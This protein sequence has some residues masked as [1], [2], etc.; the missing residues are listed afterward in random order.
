MKTF[1]LSM[2]GALVAM[3]IFLILM[4]I[5]FVGI[6]FSAA[7]SAPD[8]PD[9]IILSLD[10]NA[11]YTDQAPVSGFAAFSET[12]G[13]VDLLTKL[14]AAETDDSVKGLYLRGATVGIGSSRAE[15][16]REALLSFR[17]SGKFVIAHT[18][19]AFGVGGPSALRSITPADEVWIQP[20][21]EVFA[22]GVT[23][24][25]EFL[26]GLFDKIDVTPEIYPFYEYKNAPN[27]YNETSYTEPHREA[28]TQLA[29]SLW[30]QSLDDIAA[31]RDLSVADVKAL[32]E[33]GPMTSE[34]AIANKLMDKEGYPEEAEEAAKEKA[35]KGAE[36]MD[37]ASYTP[38][39]L[40]LKA[41]AIAI[42]GGEGAVVTGSANGGS[43][44]ESAPAFASDT[45]ARAI[46]D[47][48]KNDKVKAIV[49]RVDSPGGSP[50]ASDQIWNAIERVQADGKPVVVSMGSLAA[51]G[52]Y[53]VSA[54]ADYIVANR[55]TITGSIG[56]FGG[57]F[58]LA[59]GFNKLGITFDTIS[60]GG[61]FADAYG[62]DRFTPEQEAEVKASLKR[63]YDR[64]VGIVAEGRGMTFD[65]VN[66]VARGHVW[67]GEDALER[68]LVDE[69][70]S[71]T[72]AIAKAKELAGIDADTTPRLIYYP[73][74]KSGFEALESL[75][76]ASA[77]TAESM[78]AIS[79]LTDDKRV[80]VLLEELATAR[81]LSS[82]EAQAMGPRIRER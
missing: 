59:G 34:Q 42:V 26:K 47:A 43:P 13:F 29:E 70:G 65:E 77:E 40:P 8:A 74:R 56:I 33:S 32:L 41:P 44:F 10:L 9:N 64:F 37:L 80:Q 76:G 45:V 24:E 11:E 81:A 12:P 39:S 16:L 52:G 63:G 73:H 21:S 19:G 78:A 38:P 55:S 27:S 2:A 69:I 46:L 17:D 79:S 3:F 51:S 62:M 53:Y 4:A 31:D 60:V 30:T 6:I 66:E 1:F 25:T 82:G 61:E 35:G 54:G 75:F 28:M 18:Q 20:G 5:F 22:A 71:Y 15:E 57:K 23:F 36:F 48:G 68:G 14:Q 58:A 67:S 49:F 7:S 50:T 72:D